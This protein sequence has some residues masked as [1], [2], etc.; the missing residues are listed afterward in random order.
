MTSAG[1]PT[2]RRLIATSRIE[3]RPG[4]TSSSSRPDGRARS[5]GC[6]AI[7]PR[8]GSRARDPSTGSTDDTFLW[9][10]ERDGWKHLYQYERRWHPE[11][12]AHVGSL[13]SPVHRARRFQERLDY[14]NATRDNPMALKSLSVEAR[15]ADRAADPDSTA[16]TRIDVSPDGQLF[17]SSWSDIRDPNPATTVCGRRPARAHDRLQPV[18][19]S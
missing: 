16:A 14:F 2:A 7:R 5:S 13:G 10:S 6:S 8:P 18:A 12:P 19:T 9:L 4:S 1:G 17:L 15:R 11:G 3:S